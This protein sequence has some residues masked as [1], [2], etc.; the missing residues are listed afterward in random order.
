MRKLLLGAAAISLSGCSF[1]GIGGGNSQYGYNAPVYGASYGAPASKCAPGHAVLANGNCLSRLNIEGGIGVSYNVGGDVITG[2]EATFAGT[3]VRNVEFKDA[4]ERGRRAEAGFSYATNAN[5]KV[6][7]MAF[8]DKAESAG[9][10]DFGTID[11]RDFTGSLSDYRSTGLELGVRRYFN[12]RPAPIVRSLRPYIEAR[13]GAA[14]QD[15]V[16][17]DNAAVGGDALG[18]VALKESGW[19]PSAAGLIGVETP[20]TRFST[21]GLET[22]IR[23]TGKT[24]AVDDNFGPAPFEGLAEGGERISVPLMLRGRYRF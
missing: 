6:T 8:I 24:D 22:G 11:G 21:I 10:Q 13:V 5:T 17:I 16:Y 20:L 14:Y 3:D 15:S 9:E 2:D 18:R 12:P 19:V 1:L 23:Y 4:Y 7:A